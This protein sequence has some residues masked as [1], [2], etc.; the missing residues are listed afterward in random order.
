MT[1]AAL[2]VL[3][4]QAAS[5]REWVK[6]ADLHAQAVDLETAQRFGRYPFH[7]THTPEQHAE[8]ERMLADRDPLNLE[9]DT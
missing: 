8:A 7:V 5:R 4:I 6:A 9:T 1:P 2:R 3:A